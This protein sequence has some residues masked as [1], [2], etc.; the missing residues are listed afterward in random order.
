MAGAAADG[1]ARAGRIVCA[2]SGW[3]TSMPPRDVLPAAIVVALLVGIVYAVERRAVAASRQRRG[4]RRHAGRLPAGGSAGL[5]G[6]LRDAAG[7]ADL[8]ADQRRRAADRGGAE[9]VRRHQQ[10]HP[11]DAAVL[12]LGRPDHG[13]GRHQPAP[14]ALRD[15]AG[16]PYARRP[17]AGRGADDLHGVGHFRLEDRRC[18]RGRLGAAPRIEEA[19]LQARA[20]RRRAGVFGGDVGDHPAEPGHA[21]AGIG[22]ADLDRDT[23]HRRPAAGRRDR[24]AAD[25]PELCAVAARQHGLGAARDRAG[26]AARD[27]RRGA[28]AGDAGHHGDRHPLRRRDADRGVE[29][30]GAVRPGAGL[31]RSIAPSISRRSTRSRWNPACWRAWCCSSSPPP[32]R[33]PGR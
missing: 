4:A 20:G 19:G 5:A 12:H 9:H 25:G 33:S 29:R 3:S 17:A 10:L 16:R 32:S 13:E 23:V 2:S 8:P 6:Q 31:R 30:R 22:G 11:A 24:A 21:G 18:R 1:R 15:D 27:R 28:A 26:I 14:G 7:L